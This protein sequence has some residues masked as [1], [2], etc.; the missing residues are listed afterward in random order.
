MS[1]SDP[2]DPSQLQLTILNALRGLQD[3]TDPDRR[4]TL[5]VILESARVELSRLLASGA[6]RQSN[7]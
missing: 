6:Q 3:E 1:E 7:R 5:E 2:L 4:A